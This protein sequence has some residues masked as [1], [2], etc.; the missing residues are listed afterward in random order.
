MH[1]PLFICLFALCTL[2]FPGQAQVNLDPV[3]AAETMVVKRLVISGESSEINQQLDFDFLLKKANELRAQYPEEMTFHQI[4]R[5]GDL[6]TQALRDAGYKFHYVYLPRQNARTGVVRLNVVEVTLDGVS[7]NGVDDLSRARIEQVFDALITRPVYQPD[8]DTALRSLKAL[9]ELSLFAYYSRGIAP[10]SVRLN[11]RLSPK[12][13]HHVSVSTD[14]FGSESSGHYRATA[15]YQWL[16]PL[17]QFDQLDLGLMYA[18]GGAGNLYGY[19]SY[20]TPLASVDNTL[21]LTVSNNQYEVGREFS[22][23]ELKGDAL[24]AGVSLH[25]RWLPS[26]QTQHRV[27]FSAF[28][29]SVDYSNVFDDDSLVNDESAQVFALG[30]QHQFNTHTGGYRAHT[31]VSVRTGSHELTGNTEYS[32]KFA[33]AWFSHDSVFYPGNQ[34]LRLSLETQYSDK[35]LPSFEKM[36]LTGINGVKGFYAGQ[37]SVDRGARLGLT[38]QWPPLWRGE[39][40]NLWAFAYADAA[41]GERLDAS[42]TVFDSAQLAS[43]GLGLQLSLANRFFARLQASAWQDAQMDNSLAPTELPLLVDLQYRW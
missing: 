34:L 38:W 28:D 23:L 25:Q 41:T 21:T 42:G 22:L 40:G 18:D 43:A 20:R 29:K 9:P 4:S 30:W 37:V 24:I 2:A 33:L 36:P 7:I 12:A 14:N 1:W 32:D 16:S 39:H 10:N 11:L 27:Y 19:V 31:D 3:A 26:D 6:L 13:R 35:L 8:I 15:N 5:L 17:D